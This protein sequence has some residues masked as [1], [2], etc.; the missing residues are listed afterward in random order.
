[1]S[2]WT[3]LC[4]ELATCVVLTAN[5]VLVSLHKLRDHV[6]KQMH[7]VSLGRR[8]G[9]TKLFDF[10]LSLL[11]LFLDLS[12]DLWQAMLDMHKENARKFLG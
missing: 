12:D 2:L 5:L 10:V 6:P 8:K 9:W 3:A 4:C 1:L 11:L 7:L